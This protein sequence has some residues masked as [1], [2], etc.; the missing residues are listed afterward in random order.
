MDEYLQLIA[1]NLGIA[2]WLL[3]VIVV[4]EL[5]WKLVAMWKAAQ[6]KSVLWFIVL[7]LLNTVG[8]FSILYIFVFSKYDKA[9]K[10]RNAKPKKRNKKSKRKNRR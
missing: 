4:W 9:V 8:I 10:R 5:A 3:I 2:V 6:N 7:A 1:T